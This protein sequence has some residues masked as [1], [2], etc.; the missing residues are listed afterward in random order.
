MARASAFASAST[1]GLRNNVDSAVGGQ[2]EE[3]VRL[4]G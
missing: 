2:P 3:F 1:N 4:G